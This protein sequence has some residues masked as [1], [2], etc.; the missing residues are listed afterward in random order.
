MRLYKF[1]PIKTEKEL[2]EAIKY[3][4]NQTTKLCKK[5]INEKLTITS[6][7]VFSH[8]QDEYVML[9]GIMNKIGTPNGE[10]NGHRFILRKPIKLDDHIITYLRIR[11]PDPYRMQVGCCDFDVKKYQDF[12][13]VHLIK[14]SKNLRLIERQEYEMIEF[15]DPDFDVLAYVVSKQLH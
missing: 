2:I 3:I 1:S 10:N 7:T 5:S 9:I 15:F 12:K 14:N 11:K 6:L 4:A 8:Y 13:K